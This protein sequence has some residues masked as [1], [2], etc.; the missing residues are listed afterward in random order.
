MT[1]TKDSILVTGIPKGIKTLRGHPFIPHYTS[2]LGL[3]YEV[4]DPDVDEFLDSFAAGPKSSKED[5]NKAG[6]RNQTQ[7]ASYIINLLERE[8]ALLESWGSDGRN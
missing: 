6:F 8:N 2:F 3:P 5:F 1:T 7:L 4:E